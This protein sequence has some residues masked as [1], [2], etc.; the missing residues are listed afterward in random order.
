[1]SKLI[2]PLDKKIFENKKFTKAVF[3][4]TL[5]DIFKLK[6]KFTGFVQIDKAEETQ[7][8]LFYL[9][10]MCY[11]SGMIS[12]SRPFSISI[13]DFFYHVSSCPANVLLISLYA[14]DPILLKGILV[15]I[16]KDPTIKAETNIIDMENIVENIRKDGKD[17]FIILKKNNIMNIFFF[18]AGK[19]LIEYFADIDFEEDKATSISENLLSY[20]YARKLAVVEAFIYRD[21]KTWPAEDFDKINIEDMITG[22]YDSEKE[23][24]LARTDEEKKKLYLK[25]VIIEGQQSGENFNVTLPCVIGRKGSDI[26]IK[27]PK[28]SRRHAGIKQIAGQIII[29]DFGSTNGTFVNNEKIKLK[30]LQSGDIILVGNTK[31]KVSFYFD[32]IVHKEFTPNIE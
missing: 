3:A 22:F 13:K 5:K 21:I 19:A 27:D 28:V 32:T 17:A 29:E 7:Y 30:K 26:K 23:K 11:A 1:M 2:F 9:K 10:G 31:I 12:K 8:F 14:I 24:M 25:C 20:A 6:N 16:Q 18:K 15:F 4:Q